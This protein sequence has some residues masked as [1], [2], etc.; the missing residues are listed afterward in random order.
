MKTRKKNVGALQKATP[1]Q[2]GVTNITNLS[3]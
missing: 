1:F 3:P 2:Q